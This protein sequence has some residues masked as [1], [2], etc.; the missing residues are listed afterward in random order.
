MT[1]QRDRKMLARVKEMLDQQVEELDTD[2]CE[3]LRMARNLAVMKAASAPGFRWQSIPFRASHW[4]PVA[5]YALASLVVV[6]VAGWFWF[7]QPAELQEITV[8]A[9]LELLAAEEEPEFYEQLDF[10]LW[11]DDETEG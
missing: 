5:A 6:T 4:K 8:L 10:Y 1:D 9:D 7:S 2:T 3:R 11:L